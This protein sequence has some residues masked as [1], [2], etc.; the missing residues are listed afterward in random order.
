MTAPLGYARAVPEFQRSDIAA[1]HHPCALALPIAEQNALF[2]E[3]ETRIEANIEQAVEASTFERG[4]E[5]IRVDSLTAASRERVFV[6]DGDGAETEI[7]YDLENGTQQIPIVFPACLGHVP[8]ALVALTL[9]DAEPSAT[10]SQR[11]RRPRSR[12]LD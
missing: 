2:A 5:T 1:L 6:H 11:P 10:S 3:L 4:G 8:T 7:A 9:D 12:R